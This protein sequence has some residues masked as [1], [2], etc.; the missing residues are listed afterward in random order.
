MSYD[1]GN[2][3]CGIELNETQ[4]TLAVCKSHLLLCDLG[5]VP[6]PLWSVSANSFDLRKSPF[7]LL[8]YMG[9][10]PSPNIQ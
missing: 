4:E 7:Y 10:I 5:Q 3:V 9:L 6:H 2:N 1:Q 8:P